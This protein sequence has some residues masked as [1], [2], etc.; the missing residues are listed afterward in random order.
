[1]ESPTAHIKL[2][3]HLLVGL[4]KHKMLPVFLPWI[5]MDDGLARGEKMTNKE[6]PLCG[7]DP[8]CLHWSGVQVLWGRPCLVLEPARAFAFG[9]GVRA[10]TLGG[11]RPGDRLPEGVDRSGIPHSTNI[12][13]TVLV[14]PL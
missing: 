1:M 2:M 13:I 14:D 11:V 5:W 7:A 3:C 12:A 6:C 10:P 4:E 9:Q 8:A